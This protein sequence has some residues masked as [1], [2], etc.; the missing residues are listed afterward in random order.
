[1]ELLRKKSKWKN[2]KRG[3]GTMG[4]FGQWGIWDRKMG[5]TYRSFVK[6]SPPIFSFFFE[7]H[8]GYPVIFSLFLLFFLKRGKYGPKGEIWTQKPKSPIGQKKNK[9]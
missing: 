9:I 7:C 1:M 8:R 6:I 4:K 3:F 5:K 2:R